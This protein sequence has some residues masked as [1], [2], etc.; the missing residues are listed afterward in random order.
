M[1]SRTAT[2]IL[3]IVFVAT[4]MLSRPSTETTAQPPPMVVIGRG[5]ITCMDWNPGGTLLAVGSNLGVW[6]YS[7]ALE[8][9][10]HV[11][12]IQAQR[13]AWHP[14]GT[15]IAVGAVD[16]KLYVVDVASHALRFEAQAHDQRITSVAWNPSGTRVGTASA[17]GAVKLWD[18]S[19]GTLINELQGQP[20]SLSTLQW[21]PTGEL[22]AT[23]DEANIV[24][25]D[26]VTG[27]LVRQ[28]ETTT[29][30]INEFLWSPKG[31]ILAGI[32]DF[33]SDIW[34]V[35]TGR[36]L[37][38]L[39]TS[40][41]VVG[42]AWSDDGAFIT[43]ATFD[44]GFERWRLDDTEILARYPVDF[45]REM[46]LVDWNGDQTRIAVVEERGGTLRILH[47][48]DYRVLYEQHEHLASLLTTVAW[49]PEGHTIAVLGGFVHD[50][51][52]WDA[53]T[54]E[55]INRFS[56]ELRG[57]HGWLTW[58]P[59]GGFFI[60][61]SEDDFEVWQID[62]QASSPLGHQ[63][64]RI[65][66]ATS[67]TWS[68]DGR[69][70][71]YCLRCQVVDLVG[72][73]ETGI[74]IYDLSTQTTRFLVLENNDAPLQ[75]IAWGPVGTIASVRRHGTLELWDVLTGQV[76]V[77]V[78]QSFGSGSLDEQLSLKWNPNGNVLAVFSFPRQRLS[79]SYRGDI[80]Y[81]VNASDGAIVS[82]F[83]SDE[84]IYDLEWSADG[85]KLA[86]ASDLGIQVWNTTSQNLLC[87]LT[88]QADIV[89]LGVAWSPNGSQIAAVGSDDLIRVWSVAGLCS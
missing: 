14:D 42:A 25:W 69:Q 75:R 12:N 48:A 13:V 22:F 47:G 84:H 8:D 24:L 31:D 37:H 50:I 36:V 4:F 34:S 33:E 81:L 73:R 63:H 23:S 52:L 72:E 76:V 2:A 27:Q 70:L 78:Q 62:W 39:E 85:T 17:S 57:N 3:A 59:D 55:F 5:A 88:D 35:E 83:F 41:I 16:G 87:E 74:A 21:S 29:H 68:P 64:V 1:R 44:E 53:E 46:F 26:S 20:S 66:D 54:S 43:L 11:P 6:I 30:Q 89:L 10:L 49:H 60:A 71:A 67:A 77:S 61:Q 40:S 18:S 86:I 58:S 45:I 79:A 32:G 56:A 19:T 15:A 65:E 7:A 80:V 51:V 9:V 82:E 38:T 28:L